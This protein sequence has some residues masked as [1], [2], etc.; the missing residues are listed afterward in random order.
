VVSEFA[1]TTAQQA[2]KASELL[3]QFRAPVLGVVLTN[4]PDVIS[5]TRY[6]RIG[7]ELVA[8]RVGPTE[9]LRV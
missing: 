2:T 1:R 7:G 8:P 6:N 5:K 4:V 3:H 9:S